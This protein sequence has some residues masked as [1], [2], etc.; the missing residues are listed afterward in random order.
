MCLVP[1]RRTWSSSSGCRT[2]SCATRSRI[3]R[4]PGRASTSPATPGGSRAAPTWGGGAGTSGRGGEVLASLPREPSVRQLGVEQ[5]NTS[6]V[7]ADR[8][9]LKV[10]RKLEVG[11]SPEVEMG[12]FLATH[13]FRSTPQLLAALTFEGPSASEL[14]LLYDFVPNQGDGWEY[15]TGVLRRS[16][17]PSSEVLSRLERLGGW[18]RGWAGLLPSLAPAAPIPALPLN[19]STRKISSGGAAPSSVSWG[20]PW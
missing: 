4:S 20:S 15:L 11:L 10:L 13:G 1:P 17:Q 19:L 16:P 8:V 5:S 12:R 7:V 14:A 18:G 9:L 2:A 6:V 3:R